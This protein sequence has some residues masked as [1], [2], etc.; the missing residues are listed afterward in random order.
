M[1]LIP[2]CDDI[3]VATR[4]R[5]YINILHFWD[6]SL[7]WPKEMTPDVRL[8]EDQR[9][10]PWPKPHDGFRHWTLYRIL[11]QGDDFFGRVK[12]GPKTVLA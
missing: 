11:T 10:G 5:I 3:N 8:K 7:H 4:A 9:R 1:L 2:V 12:E 6:G